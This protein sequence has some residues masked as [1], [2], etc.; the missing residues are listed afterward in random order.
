MRPAKVQPWQDASMHL[1]HASRIATS[2]RTLWRRLNAALAL[3]AVALGNSGVGMYEIVVDDGV[4]LI[5]IYIY[6][7]C[8]VG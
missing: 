8:E 3:G 7:S 2:S 1:R 5:Y 6:G 4:G